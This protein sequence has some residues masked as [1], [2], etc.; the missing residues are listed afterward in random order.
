MKK[1]LRITLFAAVA[2]MALLVGMR[3]WS[4]QHAAD[5]LYETPLGNYFGP[6]DAPPERTIAEFLDYRCPAC[7][8]AGPEIDLFHQRHPDIKIII[9]QTPVIDEN[10]I[11]AARMALAAGKQ[12]KFEEMHHILIA[13]EEPVTDAD[14]DALAAEAGL[15]ADQLRAD[16]KSGEV[17]Q[18]LLSSLRAAQALRL[19]A[20]PS[21]LINGGV[22]SATVRPVTADDLE[23]VMTGGK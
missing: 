23:R 17:T 9:K 8:K 14:I 15:A 19:K 13:R 22:F 20:T 18:E 5:H 16:M 10:S 21:F 3:Y 4:L 2:I 11:R 12:G 7:R 6:A 1:W